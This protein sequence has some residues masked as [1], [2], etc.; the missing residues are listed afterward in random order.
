MLDTYLKQV[1]IRLKYSLALAINL[2]Q[3]WD[4]LYIILI[5]AIKAD[6]WIYYCI[7]ICKSM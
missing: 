6:S 2:N 3:Y 4:F 5:V 1:K 7:F